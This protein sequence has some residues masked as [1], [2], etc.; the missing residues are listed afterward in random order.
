MWFLIKTFHA[1]TPFEPVYSDRERKQYVIDKYKRRTVY[2]F[3]IIEFMYRETYVQR[4][5]RYIPPKSGRFFFVPQINTQITSYKCN[6]YIIQTF[7]TYIIS[8]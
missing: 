4:W 5:S 7:N 3:Y 6:R 8:I 2:I 1:T